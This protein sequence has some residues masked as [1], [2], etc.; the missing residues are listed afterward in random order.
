MALRN[1]WASVLAEGEKLKEDF[2]N[3]RELLDKRLEHLLAKPGLVKPVFNFLREHAPIHVTPHLAAVS[4]YADVLEVMEKDEF[5]SVTEIYLKKMQATTGDFVLGLPNSDQY[6][7]EIGLMR[8]AFHPNDLDRIRAFVTQTAEECVAASGGRLDAVGA[9]SRRVPTR[10]L[11]DYFGTPGPDETTMMGWMRSIFREIFLNVGNDPNMAQEAHRDA[12]LLNAYLD[13]LIASRKA[14]LAAGQTLPD[15]FLCRLILLQRDATEPFPDET[16]RRIVGGTIVGTADTNSKAIA[17]ALD[18]L[19]ERPQELLGA[20]E[21]ARADNDDLV[22]Q[23]IFEAL[24]FNPQNPFFIRYCVQ[25][26]TIAE[27]TERA[28]EIPVG[29]LVLVG[30]ESAMFDPAKFPD[31][32]SFRTDRPLDDYLH[33]GH[34]LH[35]CFGKYIARVLIPTTA[36]ALLKRTSLRRAHGSDGELRYD[37]AF[38]EEWIVEFDG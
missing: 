7:R 4:L 18:Q 11:G 17:Q 13:G 25:P 24:R 21:A 26:A 27:G 2:E 36:K 22:A 10:L 30:T 5:F 32:D 37:G 33:F 8:A 19:M 12:K 34:G 20:Q 14:E 23:Y 9:L 1:L 38:P 15:D 35:T 3:L 6:Q 16:I 28:A 29:C 31:P